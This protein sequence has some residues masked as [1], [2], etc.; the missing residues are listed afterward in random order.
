[1]DATIFFHYFAVPSLFL[2]TCMTAWGWVSRKRSWKLGG[3]PVIWIGSWAVTGFF[4]ATLLAS[5]A[6]IM[7]T[8]FVYNKASLIWP[9]CLTLGALN[10]RP[11]VGVGSLVV[12]LMG[13]INALYYALLSVLAWLLLK[14]FR[15]SGA[16]GR[17]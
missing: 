15:V 7:N 9:F 4:I 2:M 13:V 17:N 5:T 3:R 11:S 12:A 16:R 8:D 10:G 14:A 6:W 1:M